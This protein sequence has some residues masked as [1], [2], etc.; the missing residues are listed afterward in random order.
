VEYYNTANFDFTQLI[1]N[2]LIINL[3]ASGIIATLPGN[4]TVNG[5]LTVSQGRFQINNTATTSRSVTIGGNVSVSSAGFIQLGTGNANHT[6][7]VRGD[8]TNNGSVDFY[9]GSAPDYDGTNYA[10]TAHADV[11]FNSNLSDQ[12]LTCNGYSE[13][14]RIEINKGTDWTYSLNINA[15]APGNFW[16]YGSNNNDQSSPTAVN[17]KAF[18]LTAGTVRLGVNITIPSLTLIAATCTIRDYLINNAAQLIIDGAN[19]STS[20]TPTSCAFVIYG[21]VI[22]N[23]GTLDAS[24]TLTSII[25]R[26]ASNLT[27]NGGTVTATQLRTSN[28]TGIHRGAFIMTGGTLN[29]TTNSTQL[30][31]GDNSRRHATM[32]FT[33]PDNVF[34]MTGG[35]INILGS[36]SPSIQVTPAPT[37]TGGYNF[38]LALGA[39]PKNVTVTGGT[40]HVTIPTDRPAWITSMV[41]F[42]NLDVI[43]TNGTYSFG[44]RDFAASGGPPA[45]PTSVTAKPLVVLNNFDLH[46]L[47]VFDNTTNTQSVFIG[48]NF[49][50]AAGTS[51]SP[52][53][54]TTTFNGSSSQ[55][56]DIQGTVNGN[57]NNL[58]LANA[59]NLTLS[60]ANPAVPVVVNA[61]F[62]GTR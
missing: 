20:H 30:C 36:T 24:N 9:E 55:T 7:T 62:P 37:G 46:N 61:N 26:E 43:G 16:L 5:N 51:Y 12:N 3:S 8:F 58:V 11:I 41:P 18:G 53:V 10:G 47:A 17:P 57:L 50:V 49:T 59:S 56:F 29:L 54:N 44:I 22:V 34:M 33:Y 38:S 28:E 25:M 1:Y 4:M 42:W 23:S 52:A 14:Y 2:N 13:F 31:W 15:N 39:D 19:V 21:K 6:F 27:I 40:I 32:S 60:N 48:G 35:T 45:T